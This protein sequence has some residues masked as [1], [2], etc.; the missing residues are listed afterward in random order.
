MKKNIFA[1]SAI[2]MASAIVTTACSNDDE[3]ASEQSSRPQTYTVVIEA[4]KGEATAPLDEVRGDDAADTPNTRALSLDGKTLNA[5]WAVGEA[6]TVYNATKG[7][8]IEGTLSAQSSGANTTLT[9]TLTGTIDVDDELTLKYL[10]P[11]YNKQDGTLTGSATSI[12]KVCDYAEATVTVKSIADGSITTTGIAAFE[13]RQAIVK[14]TLQDA[15]G[16]AITAST[17]VVEVGNDSYSVLPAETTSE[18]F[19]A[20]PGFSSTK[21]S[22]FAKT[23]NGWLS[24]EKSGITFTNGQYYSINAK[25]KQTG[26]LPGKF[27]VGSTKQVHF[28]QGNLQ[29]VNSTWQFA[30]QQYKTLET[31]TWS[32]DKCDLFCWETTNNYGTGKEYATKT[33][34]STDVVDWGA[35]AISNGGNEANLWSTPTHDEWT[36]LFNTRPDAATKYGKAAVCGKKGLV[37]LPD[38]W[39][40]PAGCSF[41]SGL[42]NG[43]YSTNKY[44]KEQWIKME[45]AGA[46]FLPVTYYNVRTDTNNSP[47]AA[48][49]ADVETRDG[50]YIAETA[51]HYWSSTAINSDYAYTFAFNDT[52]DRVYCDFY[53]ARYYG[54][55]VRLVR[56]VQ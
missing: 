41:E 36:Y 17:L 20:L 38:S 9:G 26:T 31:Y 52:E 13:N 14:F 3:I 22:L 43:L 35:N 4:S 55:S 8:A 40:L 1:M 10:S 5:T 15:N 19:V 2:L 49:T 28:S 50:G 27:S 33:G 23:A 6:V 29:Y 32:S 30:E 48:R 53:G 21:V 45:S 25:M 7:T 54:Y 11:D 24:L 42:N 56:Q 34:T 46:M 51:G 47:A 37:V 12:D 44:S 39:T 16:T 18:L